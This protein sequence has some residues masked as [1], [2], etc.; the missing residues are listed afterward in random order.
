MPNHFIFHSGLEAH[1]QFC[2]REEFHLNQHNQ[3]LI[4]STQSETERM[5][6]DGTNWFGEGTTFRELQ[7]PILQFKNP[8]LI[9]QVYSE[10]SD[11]LPQKVKSTLKEKKLQFNPNG[12]GVFS[13]DRFMMGM[14]KRPAFWSTK[15]QIY[16]KPTEVYEY[17]KGKFR[18]IADNSDIEIHE[19]LTTNNKNVFAYFPDVSKN[20]KAIEI[21]IVAGA[22]ANITSQQMLYTGVAGIVAAELC[23]KAGI[24]VRIS[25]VIGSRSD[26][27]KVMA[28]IQMKD[29]S[30]P[31]D[32]NVIALLTSDARVFRYEMFKSLIK[33]YNH[34]GYNCPSSLGAI[35]KKSEI[36]HLYQTEKDFKNMFRAEKVYFTSE[37]FS[38][39]AA[40]SSVTEII[41]D[42]S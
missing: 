34:Y 15:R 21:V 28:V 11:R 17:E 30:Q 18:L 23:L 13:F 16:V 1:R 39:N 3:S 8:G 41:N 7:N 36:E 9:D 31:I 20:S 29:F 19:K 24:K 14:Y 25:V 22:L 32:K 2:K 6:N 12:L 10:V 35:I 27:K 33:L 5:L 4:A 42:L 37:I 40:V 38:L 26:D